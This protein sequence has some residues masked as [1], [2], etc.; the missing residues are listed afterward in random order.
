M[1]NVKVIPPREKRPEILR[2]AAYCRV[3]SDS[4]DQLHS[5]ATQIRNYTEEI[6]KHD[7]WEL[8][9]IYADA[10]TTGTRMDKR[11]DFNRML[12]DCRKGKIDKILVKSISRFA[13]N[14]RDCL[15]TLRELSSLGVSVQ[16]EKEN[17]NTETLTTELMVSVS[18][19][20]AQE[21]S[22]SISSNLRMSYQRRMQRGEFITC[23]APFGYKL[24]DGKN[25]EIIPEEAE[26]VRW[27]FASYL[28]GKS[29]AWIAEQMTKK[30]YRTTDGKPYWQ[31]TT[32]LYLLS[33]EKYIGDSLCQKNFTM[34][35]PFEEKRNQG[36]R[37]QYYIERT[38]PAIISRETF[39]KAQA[40]RIQKLRRTETIKGKYPL[41]LKI[42]CGVCGRAFGRRAS[43]KGR[44]S[45]VCRKHD[46]HAADCPV[47]RIPETELYAAFVRMYNKLK[48]HQDILLTPALDQLAALEDTL[49][50]GNPAMLEI[51]KAIADTSEQSHKVSALQARGLLD[52]DACTAKLRDLSAKLTELRR[53]RR[54]LLKNEDI[55]D[56][57]GAVKKTASVLRDGPET[58]R[59]FDEALFTDLV[60]KIVV[61]ANTRIRFQLYGG[62][63]LSE[64]LREGR[65]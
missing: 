28:G 44:V 11:E 18:G 43:K 19:S 41:S 7:G 1:A 15:A 48:A 57:T 45:W 64:E 60:E 35:F 63:N 54:R 12:A 38:H 5:Y 13:R 46:D 47:G 59:D 52:A 50:R 33:N 40:L 49:Q 22:I 21:E 61:E 31:E 4:T 37:D 25:L 29:A 9:D 55:E 23:K 6:S 14:T 34:S 20:L 36:E 3:S 32:I 30:G 27:V 62:I 56:V 42:V 17:I 24:R 2:V 16:F 39:E 65:R 53:E 26:A 58:L 8:I 10:A 51:N